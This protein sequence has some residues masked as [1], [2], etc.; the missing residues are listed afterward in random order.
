MLYAGIP[1][2]L[3][4]ENDN[5]LGF[6][7][8]FE[9]ETSMPIQACNISINPKIGKQITLKRNTYNQYQ[10]PYSECSVL[11]DNTLV[12]PLDD[13]SIFDRVVNTGYSYSRKLCYDVCTQFLITRTCGCN[14]FKLSYQEKG[15]GLCTD[16]DDINCFIHFKFN[17]TIILEFCLPRCPMECHRSFFTT[18]TV[19][20]QYDKNYFNSYLNS[21][22]FH[23]DVPNDTDL[24]E[25]AYNN[26][27]ELK[28]NYDTFSY[29]EVN[30][31]P[32]MSGEDLLGKIGGHLHLFIGMSLL[33]FVEILELLAFIAL[34]C[35]L[36][37]L[38]YFK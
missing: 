30:E 12:E 21:F 9:S 35:V 31:E 11:E 1:A 8:F 33:S 29:L 6:N 14:S 15:F 37:D 3:C 4:R 16:N 17:I 10:H 27:V 13:R 32:K 22:N 18:S 23:N 5:Q 19:Q 25:Y 38:S 2:E 36:R 7:F 28:I 34:R 20:Y 26:M 24:S